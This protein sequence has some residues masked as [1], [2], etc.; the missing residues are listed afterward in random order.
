MSEGTISDFT[1]QIVDKLL[2]ADNMANSTEFALKAPI[3]NAADDI[4]ILFIIRQW[5]FVRPR[6]NS[7]YRLIVR[8]V[9]IAYID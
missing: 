5:L 2:F 7:L 1:T 8:P 4:L 3:T 6:T 9:R